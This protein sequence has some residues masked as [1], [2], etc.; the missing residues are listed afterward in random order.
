[1]R[2][3][4]LRMGHRAGIHYPGLCLLL[5]LPALFTSPQAGAQTTQPL[6]PSIVL[7]LKLVSASHVKPVTGVVVSGE[8]L[9]LVPA[10]FVTEAP[11]AELPELIVLDGGTDIVT[12]GRPATIAQRSM[13]G[14]IAMLSVEGLDR[15]GVVLSDTAFETDDEF[16]LVAFPPAAEIAKGAG[17]LWL[18]VDIEHDGLVQ[19]AVSAET[20]LPWVTG[21]IVDACGYLAGL[22]LASGAQNLQTDRATET[23]FAAELGQALDS[24]QI[25]VPFSRLIYNLPSAAMMPSKPDRSASAR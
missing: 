5:L 24:M 13:S 6:S 12:H 25:S 10:D 20:P 9:V 3:A 11:E 23:I 22:S 7:V 19:T 21:A 4:W 2:F 17:P 8:G 14:G 1:M 18:P 15:L 16:H